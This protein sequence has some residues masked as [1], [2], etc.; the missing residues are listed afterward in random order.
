MGQDVSDILLSLGTFAAQWIF[1]A[2][3]RPRILARRPE[4]ADGVDVVGIW[5][6]RALVFGPFVLPF[7]LGRTRGWVAAMVG[8][9]IVAIVLLALS[10]VSGP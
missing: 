9:A 2:V 1:F 5:A 10:L 4:R 6:L 3:D 7:Y 8:V